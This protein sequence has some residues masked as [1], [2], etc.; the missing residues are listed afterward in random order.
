MTHAAVTTLKQPQKGLPG[1]DKLLALAHQL[2]YI[3]GKDTADGPWL[4][5]P[6]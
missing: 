4:A 6:L 5:L 1:A 2:G 3:A